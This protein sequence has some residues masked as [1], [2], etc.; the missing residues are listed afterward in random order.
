M[1]GLG[2]LSAMVKVLILEQAILYCKQLV[3]ANRSFKITT[4]NIDILLFSLFSSRLG[5]Q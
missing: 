4:I 1:L 2:L 3:A 5:N